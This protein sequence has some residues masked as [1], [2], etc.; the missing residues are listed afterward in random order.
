MGDIPE[1]Y[2]R[3]LE[4]ML[5]G[6]FDEALHA[7]RQLTAYAANEARAGNEEEYQRLRRLYS[8]IRI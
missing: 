3:Q 7:K 5:T 6:N 2:R 8:R 4:Q 1:K